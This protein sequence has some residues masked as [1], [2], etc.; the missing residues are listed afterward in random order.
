M[1]LL[2]TISVLQLICVV[3]AGQKLRQGIKGQVFLYTNVLTDST[4]P[5]HD[6]RSGIRREIVIHEITTLDQA[7]Q[8]NGIFKPVPTTLVLSVMSRDDGSF[9]AKLPPGTYSVFVREGQDLY[10]NLF[11]QNQINPV[12]VKPGQ[13][14]WVTITVEYPEGKSNQP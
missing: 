12:V 6:P 13:Y 7:S 2:I 4:A 11:H 1:R 5:R 14:S 8:V 9:K 10:A 3:A